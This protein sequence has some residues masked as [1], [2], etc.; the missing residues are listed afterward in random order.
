MPVYVTHCSM[1]VM[2]ALPPQSH[3][4]PRTNSHPLCFCVPVF[5]CF[6]VPVFMCFCVPV[7]MCLCVSVFLCFCVCRNDGA[8]AMIVVSG[9]YA[10]E[11]NLK[12]LFRIRGFGDAARDP[13]EFTIA[14]SDAVPRAY[15][16]AGVGAKDVQ[17]HE[18]NEA[19]SV[20][21]LANAR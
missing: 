18:I 1:F 9:K 21:A 5:M 19:F 20:V 11:N 15:K 13:V 6:C 14:P 8:A 7:F 17:F 10:R 4:I 12:P 16:H 3:P 2:Q